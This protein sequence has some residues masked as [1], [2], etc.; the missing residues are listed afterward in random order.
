MTKRN[1]HSA[2][3]P[4]LTNI[5]SGSVKRIYSQGHAG[6]A[7][8]PNNDRVML[9]DTTDTNYHYLNS[10]TATSTKPPKPDKAKQPIRHRGRLQHCMKTPPQYKS[11][12]KQRSIE[13]CIERTPPAGGT[14]VEEQQRSKDGKTE[15]ATTSDP[16]R[17]ES[18]SSRNSRKKNIFFLIFYMY[19]RA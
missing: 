2:K 15:S 6:T 8:G 17:K 19:H 9:A 7:S 1:A 3:K 4:T 16:Q 18:S 13:K 12:M 10:S 14:L 5:G 11:S